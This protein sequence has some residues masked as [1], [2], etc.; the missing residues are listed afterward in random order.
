MVLRSLEAAEL[1]AKEGIEVEVIDLR[2]LMPFDVE[3]LLE[4]VRKTG[5]MVVAHE[6]P[7]TCGYGAELSSRI[8]LCDIMSQWA[9]TYS[10]RWRLPDGFLSWGY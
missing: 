8:P 2:T 6:A 5:R 7:R 10:I 4:S 9:L 3:T 1:L